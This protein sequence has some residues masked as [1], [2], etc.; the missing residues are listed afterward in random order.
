MDLDSPRLLLTVEDTFEIR[1]R[2]LIVVPEPFL[3]DFKGPV[4]FPVELRRPDGS[5]KDAILSLQY[6]FNIPPPKERYACIFRDLSKAEVP[7]GTEI[8]FDSS[9]R[10]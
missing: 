8:Y 9:S 5:R 6:E 1:E 7:I 2:G 10:F 3:G 4:E